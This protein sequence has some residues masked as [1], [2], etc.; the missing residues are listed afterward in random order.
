VAVG[1]LRLIFCLAFSDNPSVQRRWT[2]GIML[3][4]AGLLA[5]LAGAA[6]VKHRLDL[7]RLRTLLAAELYKTGVSDYAGT[8]DSPTEEWD[9]PIYHYFWGNDDR[10]WSSRLGPPQALA[11]YLINQGL[12]SPE[13]ERGLLFCEA[14]RVYDWK[15]LY[16]RVNNYDLRR[17]VVA[18]C[19]RD[20]PGDAHI[21]LAA[22]ELNLASGD[23]PAA[24]STLGRAVELGIKQPDGLRGTCHRLGVSEQHLRGRLACALTLTGD[25]AGA[26]QQAALATAAG[27][28]LAPPEGYDEDY[29][30][31]GDAAQQVAQAREHEKRLQQQELSQ[32]YGLTKDNR[33]L[34]PWQA[35]LADIRTALAAPSLGPDRRNELNSEAYELNDALLRAY[36]LA[37]DWPNAARASGELER[38]AGNAGYYSHGELRQ[39]AGLLLTRLAQGKKLGLTPQDNVAKE[40]ADLEEQYK[41]PAYSTLTAE[42]RAADMHYLLDWANHGE[43][44]G[45]LEADYLPFLLRTDGFADALAKS[46]RKRDEVLAEVQLV[47]Q[48]QRDSYSDYSNGEL[49]WN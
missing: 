41:D 6:L 21:Q 45:L 46:G 12:V 43:L 22:G 13:L 25:W 3:A 27:D 36:L 39:Y 42:Q 20:F 19:T 9:A 8:Q 7:L 30:Y 34:V 23:F 33:L 17:R 16:P 40:R 4:W 28:G 48:P 29:S 10:L 31:Y 11:V 18:D 2:P 49:K 1:A 5:A 15:Y 32:Q 38:L 37:H 26:D 47:V 35:R 44:S 14:R 24:A